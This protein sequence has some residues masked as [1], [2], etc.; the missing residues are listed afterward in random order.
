MTRLSFPLQNISP[1]GSDKRFAAL[2]NQFVQR[3]GRAYM[4]FTFHATAPLVNRKGMSITPPTHRNSVESAIDALVDY[5]HEAEDLPT[6]AT[7]TNQVGHIC[8][9]YIDDADMDGM[10][11]HIQD[12]I[13][14]RPVLTRGVMALQTRIASVNDWRGRSAS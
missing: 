7:R 5:E 9:L 13:P 11:W 12:V 1:L 10:G 6:G 8:A 2:E 3:P 14:R 4:A